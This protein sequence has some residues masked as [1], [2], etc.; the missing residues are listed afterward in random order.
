VVLCLVIAL[1]ALRA[2]RPSRPAQP[3]VPA[4]LSPSEREA[5]LHKL[6]QWMQPGG[7]GLAA[8]PMEGPQ[9]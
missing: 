8:R 7:D 1:L 5:A 2:A 4:G 9:P 6:Q 3:A